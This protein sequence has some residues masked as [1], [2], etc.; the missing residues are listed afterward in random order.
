[1]DIRE[2]LVAEH[3]KRQTLAIVRYVGRDS[4]RFRGLMDVFLCGEYRLVQRSA[5]SVNY[6]V[7]KN[8]QLIRPYYGKLIETLER[9]DVHD[10]A[11]RNIFRM[12]QFVDIPDRY[13]GTIYDLAVRFLDDPRQPVAVR[14]FA[15]AAAAKIAHGERAL[16]DELR[17]ITDKHSAHATVALRVRARRVLGDAKP[18]TKTEQVA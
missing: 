3:S 1:M 2:A 8:P 7:E 9:E 6:C 10:A 18:R 12:L 11:H 15:L 13:A 5:W 17:L 4:K 14:V 16:L